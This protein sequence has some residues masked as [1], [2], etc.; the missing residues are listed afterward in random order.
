MTTPMKNNSRVYLRSLDLEK[1]LS[2]FHQVYSDSLSMKY[3]GMQAFEDMDQS[4]S[5]MKSYIKSEEE[6]KSIHRVISH[7]DTNEY[8][9]EIGIFNINAMHH[10]ANAYCILLPQYRNMGF[11]IDASAI[12]YDEIFGQ[13]Q[14]NRIQALVDSRNAKAISSLK[15]IGF[16]YEGRLAQYEFS[17]GEYIDMD[18]FALLKKRFYELYS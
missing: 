16:S 13:K 9:G 4:L 5:L 15:G 8:M 14:I 10:R 7:P 11:S 12:F 2:L 1:D 6:N 17:D 18:V 3:Y